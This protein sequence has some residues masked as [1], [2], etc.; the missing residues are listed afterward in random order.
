MS[1]AASAPTS[2]V[3]AALP[4]E[5]LLASAEAERSP[6]C[7]RLGLGLVR[8]RV[9]VRVRVKVRVRVRVG[10]R[11]RVRVRVGVSSKWYVVSVESR[12]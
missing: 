11:V 12:K 5:L 7:A 9:G 3:A 2:C 4:F 1:V 10:V 6:I 8:V